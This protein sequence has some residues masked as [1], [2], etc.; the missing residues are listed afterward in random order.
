MKVKQSLAY[1]VSL[2]CFVHCIATPFLVLFSPLIAHSLNSI[3]IE[4]GLLATAVLGGSY[5]IRN[6]YCQHKR[7]HSVILFALGT[8]FWIL[9]VG[10]DHSPLFG[11]Y[12]GLASSLLLL[13]GTVFVLISYYINHRY[14]NCCA[15]QSCQATQPH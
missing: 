10:V 9:H 7:E 8:L 4:I 14:L 13:T 15:H 12:H 5:I 6:G 1:V 11:H 2:T 3:A